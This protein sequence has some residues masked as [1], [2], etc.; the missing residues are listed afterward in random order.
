MSGKFF[1]V[2]ADSCTACNL[3]VVACKDEH[4]ETTQLPWAA[5]QP[6]T[7]QFWVDIKS[8]EGGQTPRVAVIHMPMF[9]QHCEN[10]PCMK[11][12]PETAIHRRPD[13]LVWIDPETCNGCRLCEEACPYDVIYFNEAENIAQKCTGCAHRVDEG[14]QPRCAEVCPHDAIVFHDTGAGD[15]VVAGE[16]LEVL[17]PEFEAQ[18]RVL[19]SSLPKASISG[20]VVDAEAREVIVGARVVVQDLFDDAVRVVESDSF[21][22]FRLDGLEDQHKYKVSITHDGADEVL[23]VVT[24]EFGS[25]L[26]VLRLRA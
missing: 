25:D 22:E 18:P 1:T 13:G 5:A 12:C 10:A 9:C 19:W 21:G 20:R 26:G 11:A 15:D 14:L 17:H 6:E 23:R 2:D 7:G 8:L 3:C 24:A 4:T 16:E